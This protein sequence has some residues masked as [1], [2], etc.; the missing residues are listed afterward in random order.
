MHNKIKTFFGLLLIFTFGTV[1]ADCIVTTKNFSKSSRVIYINP[2]NGSDQL[3][4]NYNYNLGTLRNPYEPRRIVAFQNI[5]EALAARNLANGDLVLIKSG[6]TWTN[7]D[8]WSQNKTAEFNTKNSQVSSYSQRQCKGEDLTWV[9][10]AV[11]DTQSADTTPATEFSNNNEITVANTEL[12][13]PSNPIINQAPTSTPQNT[14]STSSPRK[15]SGGSSSGGPSSGSNSLNSGVDNVIDPQ[16]TT[17]SSTRASRNQLQNSLADTSLKDDVVAGVNPDLIEDVVNDSDEPIIENGQ[18]KID[19]VNTSECTANAPWE[20]AIQTYP[21]DSEGWSIIK[22]DIETK[23]VYVSSTEGD[24][25]TG[26]TYNGLGMDDP[27][28]PGTV[29][30]YKT[31]EKAYEQIRDGKPDWILLKKGDTFELEKTI[32]LKTGKSQNAHIV[33]GAYGPQNGKRPI[34]DSKSNNTMQGLGNR[35][36]NTIL[37]I[38]FY[39]S[40]NDPKSP[41]FLGWSNKGRTAFTNLASGKSGKEF[42]RGQHIENNRF[43]YYSGG[44]VMGSMEGAIN[45]NIVIRRNE[46]LNSYSNSSHSQGMFLSNVDHILIEENILDHNGWYQ[47]RPLDVPLNTKDKGYATIFNHNIYIENS[48]NMVIR[49]NLSS[50]PSSMGMK[51]TS[52]SN[53]NTKVDTINSKNILLDT[54]VIIEGE[55]GFSLGGNTDFNNG[56]RWENIQVV[57]NVLSNVGRAK[58]TNRDIAW[59]INVN[60]WKSGLVCGN[61]IM[62]QSNNSISNNSGIMVK[63]NIGE[64]NIDKNTI[65]NQA[66]QIETYSKISSS[67]L[68]TSENLYIFKTDAVNN[69]DS[70]IKQQGYINYAN[71]IDDILKKLQNNPSNYFIIDELLVYMKKAS[72]LEKAKENSV[73]K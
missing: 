41:N 42:L 25:S 19:S 27:F 73:E 38:E 13:T 67:G 48:N 31:I 43:N 35:G 47:Q 37:G 33:F 20:N 65:I 18:D 17:T 50:R 11:N 71:Y 53:R 2:T 34:I 45:T 44:I 3:A 51:F 5:N 66:K 6:P 24:D 60:D 15:S 70:Y 46:I 9:P 28:N 56:F 30:A 72:M 14:T 8:V 32:W 4:K 54:N 39:A 21:K 23:I 22:P 62:D 1:Q 55:I 68:T 61:H 26:Q 12:V 63:G 36:Y 49:K 10:S 29:K 16:Q 58:P 40:T 57:G 69:L 7:Y 59:N 64:V 52:N